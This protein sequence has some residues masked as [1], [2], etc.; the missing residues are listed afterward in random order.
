MNSKKTLSK[1]VY[2]NCV[3]NTMI[4]RLNQGLIV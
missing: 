1:N 4:Y 2:E 3:K